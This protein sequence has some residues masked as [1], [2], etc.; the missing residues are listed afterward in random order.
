MK[1]ARCGFD[2]FCLE[3]APK[4]TQYRCTLFPRPLG[5][6]PYYG[7]IR[8][9]RGTIH[10]VICR[11]VSCHDNEE[12][13]RATLPICDFLPNTDAKAT[14]RVNSEVV[15]VVVID[16]VCRYIRCRSATG[17]FPAD[18]DQRRIGD[19][20]IGF[21]IHNAEVPRLNSLLRVVRN[22]DR[23]AHATSHEKRRQVKGT[24]LARHGIYIPLPPRWIPH[25]LLESGS[26]W[27]N[28]RQRPARLSSQGLVGVVQIL[29]PMLV[30]SM[31]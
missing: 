8:G 6:G 1:R 16:K 28:Q 7:I 29:H 27:L 26:S 3:L 24:Y 21:A 2:R 14:V 12:P 5:N 30:Y 20:R 19:V 4:L 18:H 31:S 15:T 9:E 25:S 10:G 11:K 17:D 23:N 22:G 13:Y